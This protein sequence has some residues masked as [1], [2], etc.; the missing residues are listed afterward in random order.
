[1]VICK[2]IGDIYYNIVDK[3]IDVEYNVNNILIIE[4]DKCYYNYYY[5]SIKI[6]TYCNIVRNCNIE[7]DNNIVKFIDTEQNILYIVDKEERWIYYND[8]IIDVEYKTKFVSPFFVTDFIKKIIE[9]YFEA[10]FPNY[11]ISTLDTYYNDK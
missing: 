8:L 4:S 7:Q 10:Y 9:K 6:L 2:I 11:S 3:F 1:M 5:E